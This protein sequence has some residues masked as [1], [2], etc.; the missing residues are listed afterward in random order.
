MYQM[1]FQH[2]NEQPE[3]K[4]LLSFA[5]VKGDLSMWSGVMSKTRHA[6]AL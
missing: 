1:P 5:M 2:F 4:E 3:W 6:L